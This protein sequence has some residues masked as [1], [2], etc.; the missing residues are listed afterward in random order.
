M[1]ISSLSFISI[2]RVS[3]WAQEFGDEL[4]QLGLKMTKSNEIKT[5][6]KSCPSLHKVSVIIKI[7]KYFLQKYKQY[8]ARVEQKGNDTLITSI[9]D[10]LGRMLQRKIDAVRVSF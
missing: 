5:V 7:L 1:P 4:W 10:N 6:G 9:V 3:S 8:N 2:F